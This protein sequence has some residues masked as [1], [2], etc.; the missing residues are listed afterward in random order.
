MRNMDK[1]K[2]DSLLITIDTTIREA[3]QK[4]N[5]T[6]EKI[7]FVENKRNKLLG[8]VTDGDIRRGIIDGLAL[9]TKVKDI[10][11]RD[12]I[13][14]S[15]DLSDF[16]QKENAKE[17][18]RK[19]KI[20][21]IPVINARGKV[22]DVVS[23][24][25]FVEEKESSVPQ[26][27]LSNHVVIMAGGEG[28]RLEPYTSVLPKP[29]LPVNG[30]PLI[31]IIMENFYQSGFN[32]FI[33]TLNYKKEYIKVFLKENKFPYDISWIQENE[34]LGTAGSLSLLKDNINETFFVTNCDILFSKI[35]LKNILDW[36]HKQKASIT[37]I[38]VHEEVKI[39]YGVLKV[40]DG[41]VKRIDEKPVIDVLINSGLYIIEP[42]II[43]KIPKGKRLDMNE[44]IDNISGKEKIL[45]Y[46][47]YS[48]WVDLGKWDDYKNINKFISQS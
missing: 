5:E 22:M 47:I 9:N 15:S 34:F 41:R 35:E 3:M 30:K 48:G 28:K 24:T 13:T 17:I 16:E 45:V 42:H 6:A 19:Y 44:L 38:G 7:L 2:L 10:M 32:R 4:L 40:Y 37:I 8:T 21:H 26:E 36:H 11:H 18:I 20:D 1:I 46:P 14:L 25:D 43:S 12:F 31:E 29:L 33:Y 27:V 23:F 39:P